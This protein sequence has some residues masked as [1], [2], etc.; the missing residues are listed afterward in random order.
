MRNLEDIMGTIITGD[1][2]EVMSEMPINSID[3]IVT[4]CPYGVGINYDVHDDDM[5]IEEYL[6]FTTEWL[7]QAY[8]IQA[9]IER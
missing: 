5:Y 3:L 8:Q 2:R 1:C 4:S 7:T 9:I 6:K